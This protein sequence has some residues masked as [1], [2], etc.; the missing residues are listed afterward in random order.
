MGKEDSG[1][2]GASEQRLPWGEGGQA[3]WL[4][5]EEHS[6]QKHGK[7][8]WHQAGWSDKGSRVAHKA[9]EAKGPGHIA[10]QVTVNTDFY[11]DM[12]LSVFQ[13]SGNMIQF[14][15]CGRG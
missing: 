5:R 6:W 12:R 9:R 11:S 1:M 4:Q 7:H 14:M 3:T 10:L 15:F 13:Q 2:Q 8:K